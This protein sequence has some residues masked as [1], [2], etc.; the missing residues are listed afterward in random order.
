MFG[1]ATQI[2]KTAVSE[3]ASLGKAYV[4]T[5]VGDDETEEEYYARIAREE[6]AAA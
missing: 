5:V 6:Q 1:W 4:D 2:A 3:A